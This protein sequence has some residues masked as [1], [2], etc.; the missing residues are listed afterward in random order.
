MVN[1]KNHAVLLTGMSLIYHICSIN[2]ECVREFRPMVPHL[3]KHLKSLI[4]TGS[5]PEHGI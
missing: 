2:E 1:E 3:T 5:S 4:A